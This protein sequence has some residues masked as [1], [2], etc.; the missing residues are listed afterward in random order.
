MQAEGGLRLDRRARVALHGAPVRAGPN[1]VERA[2]H[3]F[4]VL[5][6]RV[7]AVYGHDHFDGAFVA[8]HARFRAEIAGLE[9]A[10]RTRAEIEFVDD[11]PVQRGRR[12]PIALDQGVRGLVFDR[13][14]KDAAAD[15]PL[16][17]CLAV[18]RAAG[19]R[20]F[21]AVGNLFVERAAADRS[22]VVYETSKFSAADRSPCQHLDLHVHHD[23]AA[24]DGAGRGH[25]GLRSP[26]FKHLLRKDDRRGDVKHLVLVD[27]ICIIVAATLQ[28]EGGLRL[29]RRARVAL[30][31]APVR[32][33]P[34]GVERAE[35]V[36]AEVEIPAFAVDGHRHL[37]DAIVEVRVYGGVRAKRAGLKDLRIG[38]VVVDIAVDLG[39]TFICALNDG[40]FHIPDASVERAAGDGRIVPHGTIERAAGDL[41]PVAHA[42]FARERAAADH[43]AIHVND[44]LVHRSVAVQFT[45]GNRAA[46]RNDDGADAREHI[47]RHLGRG[48]DVKDFLAFVIRPDIVR[49]GV[50]LLLQAEG[51]G[52]VDRRLGFARHRVPL[53]FAELFGQ[54][55]KD[56]FVV[57]K[58]RVRAVD[59]HGYFD[60]AGVFATD[61]RVLPKSA[62]RNRACIV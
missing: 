38:F 3:L 16:V 29:D 35:H 60:G 44:Y 26:A 31:G 54:R 22:R 5:K 49:A 15:R 30:H 57:L 52:F 58:R 56:V 43:A 14:I 9:D 28:A 62:A 2:E 41:L 13:P 19:D 39:H 12:F 36:I 25:G 6:R 4:A 50:A 46:R 48:G 27:I 20:S 53:A 33:G 10:G 51:H 1:A 32:A 11:L 37:D 55:G 21:A 24:G 34:D 7:R 45:A 59:G 40:I 8:C 17:N 23:V 61:L 47:V 18:E 42:H